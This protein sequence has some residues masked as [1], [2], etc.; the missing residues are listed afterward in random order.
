MTWFAVY[1][2]STGTLRSVGTS[3][4]DPLP[5]DLTSKAFGETKPEGV[6]NTVTLGFDPLPPVRVVVFSKL[7]FLQRFTV[8]ERIEIRRAASTNPI[9]EDFMHLMDLSENINLTHVATQ[10]GVGYLEQQGLIAAG[11][12]AQVLA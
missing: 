2:L 5:D 4:A 3:V 6:W 9:V 10:Q 12:A 8:Q 7:D 1:E 11:R